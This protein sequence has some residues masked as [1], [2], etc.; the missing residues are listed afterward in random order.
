V[1][2][3]LPPSLSTTRKDPAPTRTAPDKRSEKGRKTAERILD[4]AE[5]AF[6]DKGFEGATLREVADRVGIRIP[7]LYNHFD[8]KAALY[9]AVLDR[10][11]GPLL[12]TLVESAKIRGDRGQ[13]ED[14]VGQTLE[15][16][17]QRPNLPRLVLHETLAGG[18]HLRQLLQSWL[19]PLL[20]QAEGLVAAGPAADRWEHE[21]LPHLVLA[22]YHIVVGYFAIA[23][24]YREL[25][26]TDLLAPEALQRQTDFVKKLAA[27]LFGPDADWPMKQPTST[28]ETN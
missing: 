16:L 27:L 2:P 6:A 22:M 21:Q 1:S 13:P 4:V 19:G 15:L 17:A 9:A 23:P 25:N 24:L 5:E 8:S 3:S 14:I 20:D 7:S 11:I 28:S 12:K 18:E 10:G 26:G